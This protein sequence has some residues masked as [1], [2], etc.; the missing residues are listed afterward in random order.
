MR[1]RALA[2]LLLVLTA[3]PVSLLCCNDTAGQAN[4]AT[5][6]VATKSTEL[7]VAGMTCG[8]CAVTIKAALGKLDGIASVEVDADA[9]SATVR[10]DD[11]KVSA[12]QIAEK[13][14]ESGYKATIRS[15]GDV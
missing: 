2:P 7:A 12:E 6:V 15:T 4:A 1:I 14:T 10:F 3:A 5:E 13:V 9:G 8:S 11:S